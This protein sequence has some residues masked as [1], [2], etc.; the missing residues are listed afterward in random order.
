MSVQLD[1]ARNEAVTRLYL[2]RAMTYSI[3]YKK[4]FVPK[5]YS[6]ILCSVCSEFFIS[7]RSTLQAVI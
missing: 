2:L 5:W 3:Y 4:Y 7:H 1:R 6:K